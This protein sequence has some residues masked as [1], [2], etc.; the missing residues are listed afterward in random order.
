[1]NRTAEISS[2]ENVIGIIRKSFDDEIRAMQEYISNVLKS[3]DEEIDI[4]TREKKLDGEEKVKLMSRITEL[5]DHV[6]ILSEDIVSKDEALM[7]QL[8]TQD[9]MGKP[10]IRWEDNERLK[11]ELNTLRHKKMKE[12]KDYEDRIKTLTKIK[13]DRERDLETLKN[14]QTN[15]YASFKEKLDWFTV[16]LQE[17][18]EII[19]TL[20]IQENQTFGETESSEISSIVNEND[21]REVFKETTEEANEKSDF[22]VD[23]SFDTAMTSSKI[24][25]DDDM[26]HEE[27]LT[28]EVQINRA[29]LE[30]PER[31]PMPDCK[32]EVKFANKSLGNLKGH[33][34]RHFTKQII[35]NFPFKPGQACPLCLEKK[36]KHLL[37][38]KTG[39]IY[40]LGVVHRKIQLYATEEERHILKFIK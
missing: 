27:E 34:S 31:C 23:K 35:K 12:D 28:K 26:E 11:S 33:L 24:Y 17:K 7:N 5:E 40:H 8:S 13:A 29:D 39:H 30:I 10:Q 36:K 22:S 1:M 32:S 20:K 18:D 21:N 15:Y 38:H 37:I 3:K 9:R 6:A 14:A 4:L 2:L 16:A 19:R 25:D